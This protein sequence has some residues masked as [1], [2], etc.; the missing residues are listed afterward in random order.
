MGQ[1]GKSR[2]DVEAE[3]ESEEPMEMGGDASASKDD[4]DRG[5][6]VTSGEHREPAATSVSCGHDM[7]TCGDVPES[8]KCA[9]SEDTAVEQEAKR[10]RSPCPLEAL[11]ALHPHAPS[12]VEH[13]GP[14]PVAS[15]S[16]GGGFRALLLS[17]R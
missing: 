10:A 1:G 16:A 5:A 2:S 6:I 11:L 12:V 9:A 13:A 15:S 7:E 17:S 14:H 4:G 8:R 3:L